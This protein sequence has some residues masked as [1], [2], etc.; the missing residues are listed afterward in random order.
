VEIQ[1]S[2]LAGVIEHLLHAVRFREPGSR[3]SFLWD[4]RNPRSIL[5]SRGYN[6]YVDEDEIERA[7]LRLV[8]EQAPL[9][10]GTPL[11]E[12]RSTL[13]DFFRFHLHLF[14]A[15]ALMDAF[16]RF[17]KA[18]EFSYLDKDR[19]A[20]ALLDYIREIRQA[21]LYLIPARRLSLPIDY[22]GSR[23][24]LLRPTD[25]LHDVLPSLPFSVP[26]LNGLRYPPFIPEK[27]EGAIGAKD[28]WLGCIAR[29]DQEGYNLLEALLGGISLVHPDRDSR[30]FSMAERVP[31]IYSIGGRWIAR[32]DGPTFPPL[33]SDHSLEQ[34]DIEILRSLFERTRTAG[35]QQRI[36]V[37]LQFVGAGWSPPGRLSFLHN[38]IAFDAFFGQQG[39]VGSS[40]RV[41]VA[42][43]AP[44][45]AAIDDRIARLLKIRNA[46]LHGEVVSVEASSEYLSYYE[47]FK[48]DPQEDQVRILST[49]VRELSG[50]Q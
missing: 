37:G 19:I 16:R 41:A 35:I 6:F 2:G 20:S 50:V 8:N 5:G 13:L 1:A 42:G 29:S 10:A 43:L 38:A 30:T 12:V 24:L 15:G 46:L 27:E 47:L 4:S 40:I 22:V 45:I 14:D 7:A 48:C 33:I 3:F 39:H 9:L 17:E 28:C 11:S 44:G 36:E 26:P 49:C 25:N 21:R 34:K 32:L 23:I 18:S 31:Y